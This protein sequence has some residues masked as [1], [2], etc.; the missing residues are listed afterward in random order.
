MGVMQEKRKRFYFYSYILF[1]IV[2][3]I[4]FSVGYAKISDISLNLEGNLTALGQ[5]GIVI[6]DIHYSSCYDMGEDV[7]T[8]NTYYQS[9]FSSHVELGDSSANYITLQVTVKNLDNQRYVF[10]GVV[11]DTA[12]A[13][14]YSNLNIVPSLSG[15]TENVT[16]LNPA[17]ES[18]DEITFNLTFN[19]LDSSNITNQELDA[20]INFHFT[21]VYKVTYLNCTNQNNQ[22]EEYIRASSFTNMSGTTY[23]SSVQLSSTNL[24]SD[25]GITYDSD[26]S[27]LVSGTDYT[28]SSGVEWTMTPN[29]RYAT[30]VYRVLANGRIAD[31]GV[32][33]TSMV[34]PVIYLN[35]EVTVSSGDGSYD[36]PFI[37]DYFPG[38]GSASDPTEDEGV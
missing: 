9:M 17:G 2:S 15:I 35:N 21:P 7:V 16:N 24:P 14:F 30:A 1:L 23:S 11:Y 12:N 27:S 25:I 32:N 10:D 36:N 38:G 26:N 31:N 3:T 20:V 6:S 22:S 29:S 33:V 13:T 8:I 19:Y 34:R 4:L 18:G 28:Y 5:E 37:L